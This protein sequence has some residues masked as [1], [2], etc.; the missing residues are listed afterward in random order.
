MS[1][2]SSISRFT[3]YCK[4]N[5]LRA[6]VRRGGPAAWRALFSSR[7]VLF[8]CDLSTLGSPTADLQGSL[9]VERHKTQTD[10]SLRDLEEM[11]SFWNPGQARRN[12][13]ERFELGASLWL[14][15]VE[16]KLAGYG[17]TLQGHTV[18]PHFF[19]LGPDDVH[20][21]DFHVFPQYRGRGVNPSLVNSI[22]RSIAIESQGRAFIEAAEWNQAQLASLRKTPFRPLGSARKFTLL[23]HTLVHWR[24]D[25]PVRHTQGTSEKLPRPATNRR[26]PVEKA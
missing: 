18:E 16:N 12:I 4:H 9:E 3:V 13:D 23:W 20:L 15:R 14:M 2:S 6:T 21:F 10:L 5:G 25:E 1:V 26:T 7:M 24:A 19:R 8:Y 17:W 11:T 22:L